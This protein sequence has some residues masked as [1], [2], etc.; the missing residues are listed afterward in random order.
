MLQISLT[1]FLEK[2]TSLFCKV[3]GRAGVYSRAIFGLRRPERACNRSIKIKKL[4]F[5][6]NIIKTSFVPPHSGALDFAHQR[7]EERQRNPSAIFG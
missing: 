6:K 1:G 7:L 4:N 3:S 5:L 2:N